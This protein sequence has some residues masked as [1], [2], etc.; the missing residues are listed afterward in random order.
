[1]FDKE[2]P[3]NPIQVVK[4]IVKQDFPKF[5]V[6]IGENSIKFITWLTEDALW[7]RFNT[8]SQI[9]VLKGEEREAAVRTFKEALQGD[10]VEKNDKGEIAVH[11]VTYFIW[12]DRM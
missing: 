10:D 6:P 5:S 4:D 9:A 3:F 7:S 8:L 1:M 11:G 12:T 2:L